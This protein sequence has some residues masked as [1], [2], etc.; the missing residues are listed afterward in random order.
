MESLA[1]YR[2]HLVDPF[3]DD[4]VADQADI[5]RKWNRQYKCDTILN[6]ISNVDLQINIDL[7]INEID[8]ELDENVLLEFYRDVFNTI[9]G[10]FHMH[11]LEDHADGKR[12]FDYISEVRRLLLFCGNGCKNFL[13]KLL[14]PI[15]DINI[16]LDEQYIKENF[17]KLE[18][19][20]KEVSKGIPY[21]MRYFLQYGTTE[22]RIH[23]LSLLG[24][25][26]S[27]HVSAQIT[28]MKLQETKK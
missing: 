21:L 1:W 16:T 3:A 24:A 14:Y 27:T 12:S 4:A 6:S 11:A 5:N 13:I 23:M 20:L 2:S 26:E 28:I 8:I 10:V 15:F 9:I 17:Y 22:N 25:R 19:T 18:P 7:F